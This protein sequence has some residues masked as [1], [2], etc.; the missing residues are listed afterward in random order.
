MFVWPSYAKG[1]GGHPVLLRQGFA[2]HPTL[3]LCITQ[4]ERWPAIRSSGDL[5]LFNPSSYAKGFGGHPV[6]LRQGFAGHS[7]LLRQGFGGH[8]TLRLCITQ[9][10]RRMVGE[11]GLEPSRV[12][13]YASETYA[14]TNSA[15]RPCR[16]LYYLNVFFVLIYHSVIFAK[17][18]E[19]IRICSN[20]AC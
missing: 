16:D 18:S 6:P 14:Y 10:E 2:G 4:P 5:H 12:T 11:E 3:R 8:P 9:P 7:V 15:T 20:C 13:P 1:F 19:G 17:R